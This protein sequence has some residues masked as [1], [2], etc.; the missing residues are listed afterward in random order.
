M[1]VFLSAIS[2]LVLSSWFQRVYTSKPSPLTLRT[3]SSFRKQP[4]VPSSHQSLVKDQDPA[5]ATKLLKSGNPGKKDLVISKMAA[6]QFLMGGLQQG[7][8]LRGST[9]ALSSPK[10]DNTEQHG[11]AEGK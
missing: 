5:C 1:P 4:P 8:H 11:A 2:L 3:W 7:C 6:A 9:C 10:P